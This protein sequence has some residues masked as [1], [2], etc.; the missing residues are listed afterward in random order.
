VARTYRSWLKG[1]AEDRPRADAPALRMVYRYVSP[2][3]GLVVD[4]PSL[5]RPE[6]AFRRTTYRRIIVNEALLTSAFP[7][8]QPRSR[9][10]VLLLLDGAL[11]IEHDGRV[12]DVAPGEAW[13]LGPSMQR[14]AWFRNATFLDLEWTA[15]SSPSERVPRKLR[16]PDEARVLDVS[17]ELASG[18][19]PQRGVLDGVFDL[20]RSMGAPIDFSAA[21]L[22]GG[23]SRRDVRIARAME[24]QL[25]SLSSEGTTAHLGEEAALSPRQLQ[26]V[27]Q[28]FHGRY[29]ANAGNWRDTRNRWRLQ[30]AVALLSLPE[31]PVQVV[32]QEVGFRSGTSLARA[33]GSA[34]FPS[35]AEL[36][37]RL[38]ARK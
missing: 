22:T 23:P 8:I 27:V 21:S 3:A 17:A 12:H 34:G 32:A 20:L 14:G 31:L 18:A 36:R 1:G 30:V 37:E 5:R 29:G 15:P 26:R 4:S 10:Q 25:S 2:T 16:T 9:L 11:T 13:L 35:P 6:F 38:L 24:K 28:D 19:A 7:L 33:F